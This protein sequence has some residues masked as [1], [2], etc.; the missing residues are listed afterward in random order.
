MKRKYLS[1]Y[2]GSLFLI[3][4]VSA[5]PLYMGVKTMLYYMSEGAVRAEDYPKYV[6]PYAP[7]CVAIILA[8]L[9][10]PL[11]YRLFK[12]HSLWVSTM[13]GILIFAAGE[14]FFEQIK[15][16]TGFETEFLPISSWQMSLCVATPEALRAIGEPT[17]AQNNPVFKIHFY[18]I[19]VVIIAAVIILLY[20]FTHMI[21]TNNPAKKKPLIVE[22]ICVS[23]F[24]G[25]CV[26]ACLTA[27]YRNGTLS[28]SPLSSFLT[29]FFFVVLGVT[30]GTYF[31]S[32]LYGKRR[33][34][35]VALPAVTAVLATIAMYCGELALMG[36]KLFSFGSGWFFSPL[37]QT[38]FSP[39]D[40]LVI[41]LPGAVTYGIMVLLNKT[42]QKEAV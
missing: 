37:L 11:F 21:K 36:G 9:L 41:L 5:Y 25:L 42:L 33:L 24:I 12:R 18:F 6:I 10:L 16:I 14:L 39:C 23:V 35:S 19:A 17:F 20:G 28:I 4:A 29:S 40:I 15:V 26:F 13:F 22:L 27:F 32:L 8:A 30:V 3:L 7:M 38:P 1:F 31:G 2:L 34:F